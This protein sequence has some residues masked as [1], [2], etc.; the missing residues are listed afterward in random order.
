MNMTVTFTT[1]DGLAVVVDA[2]LGGT[3]DECVDHF[4]AA[5]VAAGYVLNPTE[6]YDGV[7]QQLQERRD[8][9]QEVSDA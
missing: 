9:L 8:A 6:V 2:A 3:W 5:L 4:V 7:I 1:E